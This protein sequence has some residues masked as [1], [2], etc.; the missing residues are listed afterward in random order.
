MKT[1]SNYGNLFIPKYFKLNLKICDTYKQEIF[2]SVISALATEK[3][4]KLTLCEKSQ[5][6]R[7]RNK[8]IACVTRNSQPHHH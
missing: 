6:C 8:V 4:E 2:S 7:Q 1:A 3:C 5:N